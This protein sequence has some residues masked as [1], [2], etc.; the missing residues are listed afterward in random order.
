M[1]PRRKRSIL[2]IS[3]PLTKLA[4]FDLL[5]G[6][7]YQEGWF[8]ELEPY[9]IISNRRCD[10]CTGNLTMIWP[11]I[12]TIQ[13]FGNIVTQRVKVIECLKCHNESEALSD[14]ITKPLP[15][16]RPKL[17]KFQLTALIQLAKDK[18]FI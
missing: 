11:L 1:K 12:R 18:G 6:Q 16:K 3:H 5:I 8:R 7:K 9:P 14:S 10:F 2:K 17:N 4:G 15:T 13:A